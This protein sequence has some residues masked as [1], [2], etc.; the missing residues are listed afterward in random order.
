MVEVLI[1]IEYF[2]NSQGMVSLEDLDNL[3]ASLARR[4][5]YLYPH[6]H[7]TSSNKFRYPRCRQKNQLEYNRHGMR[8]A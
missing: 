2:S 7:L 5:Y 1:V 3:T 8:Y 6:N 4:Q